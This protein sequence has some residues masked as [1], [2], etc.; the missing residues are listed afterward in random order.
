M[1]GSKGRRAEREV[2]ASL[3]NNNGK[4]EQQRLGE[5][6]ETD[7]MRSS[8]FSQ[9]PPPRGGENVTRRAR[10]KAS[11]AQSTSPQQS[12]PAAHPTPLSKP[13]PQQATREIEFIVQRR[14][15]ECEG[16]GDWS[17][18]ECVWVFRSR[19]V[20]LSNGSGG[21]GILRSSSTVC[22]ERVSACLAGGREGGQVRRVVEERGGRG[23]G[24]GGEWTR[25]GGGRKSEGTYGRVN[26]RAGVE[27]ES[28]NKAVKPKD[29]REN[30]NED[31]AN[32]HT[33]SAPHPLP[34]K[35]AA[36]THENAALLRHSSHT[37][38][39]DDS[40]REPGAETSESD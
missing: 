25:V 36:T 38:V 32:L 1:A 21:E 13:Q 16:G 7:Q 35:N 29:L 34:R 10:T 28:D 2:L 40:D 8:M 19:S 31:H 3:E 20:G 37:C 17:E 14:I 22:V 9:S 27:D 12:S 18:E 24:G 23:G 15:V 4:G 11:S 33:S 30:E 5:Q 39:S 26:A 6:G